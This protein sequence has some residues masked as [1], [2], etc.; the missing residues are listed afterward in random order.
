MI[1]NT[2]KD[3]WVV[4]Q[5]DMENHGTIETSTISRCKDSVDSTA[6][7][8]FALICSPHYTMKKNRI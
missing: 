3:K 4:S 8:K 7:G 1:N 2:S 5:Y 6:K